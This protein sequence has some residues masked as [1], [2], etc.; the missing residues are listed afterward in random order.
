MNPA[1]AAKIDG[2]AASAIQFVPLLCTPAAIKRLSEEPEVNIEAV[3]VVAEPNNKEELEVLVKFRVGAVTVPVN[4]GEASG[5]SKE[6]Q[7]GTP[8]ALIVSTY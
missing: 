5:A 2:V 7:V 3:G 4:V 8:L 6:P 1:V